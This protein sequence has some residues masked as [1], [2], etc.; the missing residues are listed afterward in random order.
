VQIHLHLLDRSTV[1]PLDKALIERVVV[2]TCK[3]SQ[4]SARNAGKEEGRKR[5]PAL[6][7]VH[8]D[9]VSR[10]PVLEIS[11]P[12][13]AFRVGSE[14]GVVDLR[15]SARVDGDEAVLLIEACEVETVSARGY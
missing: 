6:R 11:E 1:E 9:I 5:T 8:L 13:V 10:R 2:S 15:K 4:G 12:A 7:Q 3:T 14:F